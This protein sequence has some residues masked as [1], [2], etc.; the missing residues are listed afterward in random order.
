[1]VSIYSSE[2]DAIASVAHS[3][4]QAPNMIGDCDETSKYVYSYSFLKMSLSSNTAPL[5]LGASHELS[6]GTSSS[7]SSSPG[8][9]EDTLS[10]LLEDS[11]PSGSRYGLLLNGR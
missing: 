8:V 3:E 9:H 11:N 6:P 7:V 2:V 5:L 1:M 10:G 4:S